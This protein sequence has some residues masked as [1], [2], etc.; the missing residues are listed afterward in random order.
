MKINRFALI[1]LFLTI[2]SCKK[3]TEESAQEP[4]QEKV[5]ITTNLTD[6]IMTED[7]SCGGKTFVFQFPLFDTNNASSRLNKGI[8]DLLAADLEKE[9]V[10]MDAPP[11]QVYESFLRSRRSALCANSS[12]GIQELK[13]EHLSENEQF[14]SYEIAF[15]KDNAYS[16]IIAGFR[17][18]GM[19]PIYLEELIKPDRSQDVQTI[20]DVNL[21]GEAVALA[22]LA[23]PEDQDFF[24]S[25]VKN[26]VYTFEPG[27][28]KTLNV[29]FL[30]Q[31]N[32]SILLQVPKKIELPERLSYLND[33]VVIEILLTELNAYLDFS[34]VNAAI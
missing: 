13:V 33:V 23:K 21:Q 29:G 19:T 34:K 14:I 10:A 3:D 4:V 20:L 28:F 17:K 8:L 30:K 18:N 25:F 24:Q 32:G 2:A 31:A 5:V 7:I 9:K 12:K 22:L 16:T 27:S 1:L 15:K 11:Q 6:R 26:K